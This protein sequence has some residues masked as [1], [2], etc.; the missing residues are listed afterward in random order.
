MYDQMSLQGLTSAISLLEL[1]SGHWRFE[2]QDGRITEGF[3]PEAAHVSLSARQAK[4]QGLMMSGTCGLRGN[5]SSSSA[6]LQRFTESR[7]QARLSGLGSTLYKLTWKPWV[8]P[9]GVSRSRLR[10]SVLRISETERSGW[11]T[12][13]AR[14]WKDT[15]GM[16]A[17][18][19][20]KERLDQ[21]PRQAYLAGWPT[22]RA[23]DGTGDKIPP[24]RQ[25][26]LAIKQAVQLAG[27][28]TPQAHDTSGR[29][30]NQKN[31]HGT[32]HGCAC[33][34]RDMDKIDTESPARLTATGELLTGSCAGMEIGGQLNPAHS[35]WLMALPT[36]WDDCAPTETL[37]TLKRRK[38]SF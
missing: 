10:G 5:G 18:R 11:V 19:D 26:G 9:S 14:D 34:V 32:K 31:I 1:E 20:G 7:L 3:G 8:T 27:W 24:G 4:E 30:K 15:P 37:S 29:S 35:R 21:L 28:T 36:E 33:L 16:T 23:N 38:G 6:A 17:L 2:M 22:P 12:P 13:S 25:G